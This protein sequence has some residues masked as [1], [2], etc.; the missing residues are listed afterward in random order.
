MMQIIKYPRP[1]EF[2]SLLQRPIN[3]ND[4]ILET[5]RKILCQVKTRGDAALKNYTQ[6]FDGIALEDMRVSADEWLMAK[7]V[8]ETLKNAIDDAIKNI[9]LFHTAQ[10]EQVVPIET[11]PGIK[12]W[13]KP[14][15]IEKV[16]LYIP[17]GTAPLFSTLLMLAIP[18][19]I[20]GCREIV[21]CTPPDK[22]GEISPTILYAARQ[23]GIM[24]IY[25]V[26]GAQ[27]IAAM[28]YGTDTIP[29]VYKI[30]GP[31]NGYVTC[32]K[33]LLSAEGMVIDM[34]AGPS[35]LA[36]LADEVCVPAF[37]A[38]DLLSQAEHGV[39]S[40]VL[41]VSD[42]MEVINQ[43]NRHLPSQLKALPR[44]GIA[45]KALRNSKAI[46]VNNL[47]E[48][49]TLLNSYAPEH[50]IIA[51]R[52]KYGLAEKVI[53]AG[54]V[55]LGNYAPESAGDYATG[56]NHTLP[57]GG[58]AKAYSGVS[59]DSFL[60]KVTFQEL[61]QSGLERISNTVISMARA[62]SLDAHANAITIRAKT[63][64]AV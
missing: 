32:A 61:S 20:A 44:K 8:D 57:T 52:D 51:C 33:M 26:G 42:S 14:V 37:V 12:C 43:V 63:Y 17:G 53:N 1:D 45:E 39:D 60:K 27:A 3:S 47:D 54:S 23:L 29:K 62:E 18:A 5:V 10:A 13:R 41:L 7:L 49:M 40:Q 15:A 21:V 30:F 9:Q 48:G 34:P 59:L 19:R 31:G 2:A 56:T 35:E 58:F 28:A 6:A 64:E 25:K 16:G 22:N 36:I 24:Q 55:F 11:Q 46:L 38:A 50:L 4:N